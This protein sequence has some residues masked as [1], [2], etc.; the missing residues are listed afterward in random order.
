MM[1]CEHSKCV[2]CGVCES[3]CPFGA[4]Y[5]EDGMPVFSDACTACGACVN[6]CPNGAILAE[7]QTRPD[8]SELL[9]TYQNV[10]VILEQDQRTGLLRKVSL[11]LMSKARE[12]ADQL[13]QKACAVLLCAEK[14]DDL[15]NQLSCVGCDKLYLITDDALNHYQT[16]AFQKE[17]CRLIR[18]E[19][20]A[21]VLFPATENG[22]DLAPRV[23]CNL[24]VGLTADCTALELDELRQ[25]VQIRPTFGGNI[26]ASIISPN[27][28]PQ[29][30]SVRP[31]VLQVK[32]VLTPRKVEIV[33]TVFNNNAIS[34]LITLIRTIEKENTYR[35][36][37]EA[38]I[39]IVAGY[40][41]GSKENFKKIERLAI[42]MNAAIGATRKVVD[43]GWAPSEIQV[44]Q[45]GKTIAPD[46]Y[47]A[48]GVSGALQHTIGTKNA[49]YKVAIN[50]DP[51]APIF[52]Q[53]D[54]AILAD[55]VEM[56]EYLN[57]ALTIH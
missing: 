18:A 48:F 55:C 35:D 11:E 21:I 31:N 34:T 56:T 15:E 7:E 46:L 44:G 45:T 6:A 36:V 1:I 42:R 25:L 20:P 14:P 53:A 27:H 3:S 47:I 52:Q 23:S 2:S 17:I 13:Q 8:C 43:E 30:A 22:R 51:A 33:P 9:E 26:M 5:M 24:R 12:L 19:K 49:K 39:V 29:M 57:K 38:N 40:G 28:R 10:W 16:E 32:N 4:I 41:V 37:A 50:N 54:I